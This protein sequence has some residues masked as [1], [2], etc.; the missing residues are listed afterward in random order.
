MLSIFL[1]EIVIF[2]FNLERSRRERKGAIVREIL[3]LR[4]LS[5][6]IKIRNKFEELRHLLLCNEIEGDA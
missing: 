1:K 3:A 6:R 2:F 5:L 4:G